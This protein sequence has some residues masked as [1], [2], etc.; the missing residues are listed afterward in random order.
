M[1]TAL[2]LL[3]GLLLIAAIIAAN[4]YFV[5]QEFAFMTVDRSRLAA[6]AEQGDRV[7]GRMLGITRRTSFMLSGAQLGITVTGLL[8]GYVAEPLVGRAVGELL[9]GAGVAPGVGIAIGTVGVLVVST[10]VQMLFGEL[11]PKNL[12]IARPHLLARWLSASTV[13]YMRLAGWLI[14]F[15]DRSSTGLLRLLRIEPV[16][17]VEHA[18]NPRDL[19]RIVAASR[20]AGELPA[21]LSLL[22]DRVLDFPER[23]VEHALVPRSQTDVL[24]DDAT[25]DE[26]RRT[27]SSGHSRYPVLNEDGGIEGVVHLVDVLEAM[28]A[29][30]RSDQRPVTEIIRSATIIPTLMSLPDAVTAMARSRDRMACVVDEY[31]GFAGIVTVED[32]AEELVGELTDEH[33]AEERPHLLAADADERW[34]VRGDAPLDEVERELVHTLPRGDYETVSGLVIA[35]H[36]ALPAEDAVIDIRLPSDPV[37]LAHEAH[38]PV[39]TLRASVVEVDQHV[40]SELVLELIEEAPESHLPESDQ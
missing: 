13:L 29:D 20:Q 35:H 23:D 28:E 2:S 9:G 8:V 16:H 17:D 18:A 25:L 1:I 11:L 21:E 14:R 34:R 4:G 37:E 19:Q 26:V 5:A 36:G 32:L 3:G 39:R 38:P 10:F 22:L 40:P 31:G 24:A 7:A 15:F 30:P 27:M 6:Q 33:D 12:A